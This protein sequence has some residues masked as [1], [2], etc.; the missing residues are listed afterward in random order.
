M[1]KLRDV[2]C[3]RA[4]APVF[5][6][7][8][9][10]RRRRSVRA[11]GMST[12][13]AAGGADD[14]AAVLRPTSSQ[15]KSDAATRVVALVVGAPARAEECPQGGSDDAAMEVRGCE[16]C[17]LGDDW[18]TNAP[19]AAKVLGGQAAANRGEDFAGGLLGT[20]GAHKVS[21]DIT[22]RAEARRRP[23]SAPLRA[24]AGGHARTHLRRHRKH[25]GAQ[26]PVCAVVR[27]T[28]KSET[29]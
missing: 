12:P 10:R 15:K 20:S 11:L 9:S 16:Q 21:L 8:N 22:R 29:P 7:A 14:E 5:T 25:A 3:S 18:Q 24:H 13:A 6:N 2:I 1:S 23:I 19:K 26:A 17:T 28:S 4:P 27:A